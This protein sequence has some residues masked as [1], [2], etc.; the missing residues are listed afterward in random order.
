MKIVYVGTMGIPARYGGFE[1]C[2]E[3]VATRL[4][5][6]RFKT[7]IEVIQKYSIGIREMSG[8]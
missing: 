2:V 5:I 6:Q 4:S 8:K 1:T 3:E 7:T